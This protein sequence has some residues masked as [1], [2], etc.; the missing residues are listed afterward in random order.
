[1]LV[2][3]SAIT[4]FLGSLLAAT[5]ISA[6]R[7]IV[8][9]A[10]ACRADRT[11]AGCR[12]GK[13]LLWK[14]QR[15]DEAPSFLFGTIHI[16]DPRVTTLPT[17]VQHAFVGSKSFTMEL[18]FDSD[19][20]QQMADAMFFNDDRTL[21]GVVGA[22]RY[23]EI[24][25]ALKDRG[26]P[27]GDLNKKKPWVVMMLLSERPRAGGIPLDFQLQLRAALEEKP[28][29]GLENM[30]EQMAVFDGMTM[31]D[32]VAML[33]HTLHVQS[34]TTQLIEVMTQAYLARDLRRLMEII[35]S[36]GMAQNQTQQILIKRLLADRN[37]IMA[38]RMQPRLKEGNAFIA[39][40]AG[41]LPGEH[42]LLALLERAG[43]R[44]TRVY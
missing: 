6:A 4:L 24:E 22:Q 18:V 30:Q 23:A 3:V 36:A 9:T 37:I 38:Q 8:D 39:V 14:I 19:A 12:F 43:W 33:N 26:L 2:R 40:G 11:S 32:Q 5:D 20:F 17:P 34:E 13:G 16:A 42:G 29:H 7:E 25:Q 44:V 15:A 1:M 41:H 35:N 10:P 31:T 27:I 28:T 21:Q